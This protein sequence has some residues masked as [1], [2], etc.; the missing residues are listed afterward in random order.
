MGRKQAVPGFSIRSVQSWSC[1]C[2]TKIRTARAKFD[3]RC[4]ECGEDFMPDFSHLL[5]DLYDSRP[6]V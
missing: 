4:N 1:R 6:L 3:V 5:A 2:G